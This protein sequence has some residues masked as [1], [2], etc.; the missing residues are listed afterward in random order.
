VVLSGSPPRG[1]GTSNL[2]QTQSDLAQSDAAVSTDLVALHKAFGGGWR[3]VV[4]N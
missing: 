4:L 1:V 2:F 3:G